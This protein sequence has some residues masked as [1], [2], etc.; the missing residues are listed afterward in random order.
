MEVFMKSK[1][2]AKRPKRPPPLAQQPS[3]PLIIDPNQRYEL[4]ESARIL[5]LGDSTLF[6][7]MREKRIS[8]VKDGDRSFILGSELIRY[9]QSSTQP[10]A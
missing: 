8:V 1:R 6:T 3:A 10:A 5:R 4:S 2:A 7:R 9:A